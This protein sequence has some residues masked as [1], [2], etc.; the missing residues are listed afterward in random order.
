MVSASEPFNDRDEPVLRAGGLAKSFRLHNQGGTALP[1]LSGIDLAVFPGE[2]VALAGPSGIGKSSLLRLLYGNYLLEEGWL[3]IRHRGAEIDMRTAPTRLWIEVR[4]WTVGYVSQFLRVIPRVSA[5]QV[6][7]QPLVDRGVATDRA[8][9]EAAAILTR[10]NISERLH[11][12]A[13]ATFSGGEQQRV[14][15]AR[16]FVTRPPI[17]L[18]DEPT[19]SLDGDNRDGVAALICE[20]K[21][22]NTAVIGI[23]HDREVRDRVADRVVDLGTLLGRT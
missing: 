1:V 14:N 17:M 21:H 22:R 19:A 18:L 13:P 11:G 20:A 4:R 5:V 16:G 23:F 10:L 3:S 7:A 12:L 6:V 15:V 9:S 2:C 8:E